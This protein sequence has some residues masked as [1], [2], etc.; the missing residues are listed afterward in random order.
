MHSEKLDTQ[1]LLQ[2][3]EIKSFVFTF[4]GLNLKR[5]KSNATCSAIQ[6]VFFCTLCLRN[7]IIVLFRQSLGCF[8]VNLDKKRTKENK[9]AHLRIVSELLWTTA[10]K[11]ATKTNTKTA[12]HERDDC[13]TDHSH[14]GRDWRKNGGERRD[15]MRTDRKSYPK[16]FSTFFF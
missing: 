3:F 13:R 12:C 11:Q 14:A 15:C 8:H 1:K 2:T 7:K 16:Q 5:S 4:K 9:T 10:M 6:T